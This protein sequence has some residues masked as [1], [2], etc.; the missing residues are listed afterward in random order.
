MLR[1]LA[2]NDRLS[3]GP[4][5]NTFDVSRWTGLATLAG[6][7]GIDRVVSAN[8]ADFTLTDTSLVRS[9]GGAF[10]L[11]GIERATLT[12]GLGDNVL[13][14]SAF[15]G[16]VTLAGGEG[17][18]TLLGGSGDD[19]L[20]G[21]LGTD[22]V[23]GGAGNDEI[24]GGGGAGDTLAG[25]AGD[26]VIRGSDDGGDVITGGPGRDR[27]FGNGG[28]DTIS[29]GPG[30]DIVDGGPGDDII[31]GDAGSDLLL[32]GAGNDVIYG[33]SV[34]A[35]GDDLAVDYLYGDF[36]TNGNEPGSGRDQLFG[37]GGNDFLYGEGEDDLI[38]ASPG[39]HVAETS[40]GL[41]NLVDFGG[42][43]SAVPG[44]F[45]PPAPTPAPALQPASGIRA[46]DAT[47]PT[48]VD[49]RGRWSEFASSAAG[50]GLSGDPGLSIEPS[51]AAGAGGQYVAWAD[52]RNGNF[53]IY[54][55]RHTAAGW[56]EMGGS[57]HDGGLSATAGA[58]RRPSLALDATGNPMVAWTE[59]T[60]SASDIQV[61]RFDP[62]ANAGQGAWVALGSSLG[63]GG[64]SG[65]GTA[66]HAVLVNTASGPVVAWLDSAGGV[67]NVFVK[68][69]R[70]GSWVELGTGGASGT[71][72]SASTTAVA[73]FAI[74]TDGAKVAVA[75]TQ[76]VAGNDEIYLREN[77][78]AAWSELA[79]S[80]SASGI[81]N[82]AG[83]SR[84]PSLAYHAG[85]LFAAWQ[86]DSS[87]HFEI[88][89]R[90]FDALSTAWVPAGLRAA[91]DGGVSDTGGSATQPTLASGGGVLELVWLDDRVASFTGNT[92]VLYARRWNGAAFVEELPGDASA[93]GIS[94]LGAAQR[95]AVTVDANGHP[96][97]AWQDLSSGTPEIYVRGNVFDVATKYY[98]NDATFVGDGITTALGAL[99]NDGLSPAT[100]KP[101][102]QSVLD[103]YD[104]NPG[105]VILADAGVYAG[106]FTLTTTD[107]G[108]LILGS[109]EGVSTIQGAVAVSS[110]DP[111]GA[112]L[113]NLIM[114]AGAS[115]TGG[116]NITL[117]GT[118]L[119]GAGLTLDGGSGAQ[120]VHNVIEVSGAVESLV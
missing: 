106:G 23:S 72:V 100:P 13:D 76:N 20:D 60:G 58:S 50:P 61:A 87:A 9:T 4:G 97:V 22:V 89:V 88:F 44:D 1:G 43:E 86:D 93:G 111:A 51:I 85:S 12:G 59:L 92:T 32:G 2:G 31:S 99:A 3:G 53:E 78:G 75:R 115:V 54:L 19:L 7:A 104:L 108:V 28:N 113:A 49:Y 45:V 96:F 21:G 11:S 63:S 107:A 90:R 14:A 26:D 55:A 118:T 66:D 35:A 37:Q 39:T 83:S 33:H 42:G 18:D 110:A 27:I 109:P 24:R 65:T 95:A 80:A 48:G 46:A 81:S 64:I 114:S 101:S 41:S 47:L 94:Q 103:A 5:D 91:S 57:A 40:G 17:N 56:Q 71:G 117:I 10:T 6:A 69:F 8:D 52:N 62:A 36:G 68:R 79:G 82:S 84:A 74:A 70:G 34:G 30:D 77:S 105:D 16:S 120:I 116:A 102:I 73:D 119:R 15:T 25:G 98:V 29:G 67:A 38:E 112:T